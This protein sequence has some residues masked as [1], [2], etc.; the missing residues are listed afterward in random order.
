VKKLLL[1]STSCLLLVISTAAFA[2]MDASFGVSTVSAPSS[3]NPSA[4]YTP[5][6]VGG[7]AF[8]GFQGIFHVKPQFGIGGE[9]NW[10]ASRNLYLGYQPFRPLFWD[11]N[12]VWMPRFGKDAQGELMAG[13][14]AESARFYGYTTCS[15]FSGCTNYASTNHFM[16][17]VGA[18]IR[19]YVHGNLF[20]RPE[21]RLYL[22]HNNYEFSS[23]V[24]GRYGVSIGYTFGER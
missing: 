7:G 6:T 1:I 10:R 16:G 20:V 4:G 13:I 15:Y 24:A 19:F 17:D 21:A 8:V 22:I 14:G 18:G 3:S 2:Q 23:A 12:G 11:F 5:Q 9:I